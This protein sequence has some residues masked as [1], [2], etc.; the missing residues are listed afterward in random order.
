MEN[1]VKI[2]DDVLES[3]RDLG[4]DSATDVYMKAALVAVYT[5]HEQKA[6][7][8]LM[9]EFTIKHRTPEIITLFRMYFP[10]NEDIK[11][12]MEKEFPEILESEELFDVYFGETVQNTLREAIKTGNWDFY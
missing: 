12:F 4:N 10:E 6:P 2:I 1:L 9:L 3:I 11:E 5:L 7:E 8:D